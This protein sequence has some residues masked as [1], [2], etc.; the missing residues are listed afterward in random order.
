MSDK[1]ER[2]AKCGSEVTEPVGYP[3]GLMT[4]CGCEPP[5]NCEVAYCDHLL[6]VDHWNDR[7]R[8][9]RAE[10]RIKVLEEALAGI[11]KCKTCKNNMPENT[12]CLHP[13]FGEFEGNVGENEKYKNCPGWEIKP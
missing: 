11:G 9:I 1:I 12:E 13:A 2:C 6:L 8:L 5:I 10:A 3:N 4:N 7:Q